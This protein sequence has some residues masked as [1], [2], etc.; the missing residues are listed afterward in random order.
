MV[1]FRENVFGVLAF[2]WTGSPGCWQ[3]WAEAIRV[4]QNGVEVRT[5]ET[6]NLPDVEM[7][8]GT[9]VSG[10]VIIAGK[11]MGQVQ[12]KVSLSSVAEEGSDPSLSFTAEAVTGPD[13]KFEISSRVPPGRYELTAARTGLPNPFSIIIDHTNSKQEFQLRGQPKFFVEVRLPVQ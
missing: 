6:T 9:V 3:A 11:K 4:I 5:G 8:A 1:H 10:R 2:G 12:A 7:A 13:G